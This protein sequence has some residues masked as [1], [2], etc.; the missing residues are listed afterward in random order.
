[1]LKKTTQME[2]ALQY[3]YRLSIYINSNL[4]I[5]AVYRIT[6]LTNGQTADM[7]DYNKLLTTRAQSRHFN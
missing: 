1:V 4:T 2:K 7:T 3:E 5:N 6:L